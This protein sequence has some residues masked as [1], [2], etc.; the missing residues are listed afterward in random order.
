M[1]DLTFSEMTFLNSR[2]KQPKAIERQ[3]AERTKRQKK[4]RTEDTEAA[5]SRYFTSKCPRA[6]PGP[7]TGPRADLA[8]VNLAPKH[9]HDVCRLPSSSL[10]PVELPE[11]PFLGFG[12]S[13]ASLA[14]PIKP[15]KHCGTPH[16]RRRPSLENQSIAD[17]TSYYTWSHSA[18]STSHAPTPTHHHRSRSLQI[19][20]ASPQSVQASQ[21]ERT[22]V[23]PSDFAVPE[24][25]GHG[26]MRSA[27]L[28]ER[29]GAKDSTRRETHNSRKRS[30]CKEPVSPAMKNGNAYATAAVGDADSVN[31]DRVVSGQSSRKLVPKEDNA[32]NRPH[33][34]A[35]S[36]EKD[37]LV[38][39]FAYKTS[40]SFDATLEH[41]LHAGQK[42]FG[43]SA[44]P[45][46]AKDIAVPHRPAVEFEIEPLA[47]P[48]IQASQCK[49]ATT[50]ERAYH[51]PTT[52][53]S[54]QGRSARAPNQP[55]HAY[56]QGQQCR[57]SQDPQD[58]AVTQ[59]T[60]PRISH[61]PM[62]PR[63]YSSTA[64]DFSRCSESRA[65]SGG[66]W[67]AYQ[68]LYQTQL[69]AI[70][71]DNYLSEDGLRRVGNWDGEPSLDRRG[72]FQEVPYL[73]AEIPG[74]WERPPDRFSENNDPEQ[75]VCEEANFASPLEQSMPIKDGGPPFDGMVSDAGRH[76]VTRDSAFD[77]YTNAPA[78]SPQQEI[79]DMSDT[80]SVFANL[81]PIATTFKTSPT[82][83]TEASMMDERTEYQS[84]DHLGDWNEGAKRR[85]SHL[86][87]GQDG[88]LSNFWKP[89]RL[90]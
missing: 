39:K 73:G 82:Y 9:S 90:Y 62:K 69:M 32:Q 14:S 50:P 71:N 1:P 27:F 45:R 18:H 75:I 68:N 86:A 4:D 83:T 8:G 78:S 56:P 44:Q 80:K 47:T 64:I 66:A 57:E 53:I 15:G 23:A 31:L 42:V 10:P 34:E 37:P 63:S 79:S 81:E 51:F 25:A 24:H 26:S 6:D 87:V 7:G 54:C 16:G 58:P 76:W 21:P 22:S 30:D 29:V 55:T 46:K 59:L 65:H 19:G 77:P 43:S 20:L 48:T 61:E 11:R 36:L 3:A 41:L 67:N 84:H 52:R 2:S 5:I 88:H 72:S 33:S 38:T 35:Q 60:L 17:S 89:N 13:G 85:N 40:R 49:D 12:S 70:S 74:E 28:G